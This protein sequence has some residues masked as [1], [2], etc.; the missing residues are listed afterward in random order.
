MVL[1]GQVKILDGGSDYG[2]SPC[3]LGEVPD[4]GDRERVEAVATAAH[5][6]YEQYVAAL[7]HFEKQ[8]IIDASRDPVENHPS[9]PTVKFTMQEILAR[10]DQ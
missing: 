8:E 10:L 2:G 5:V 9:L 4:L 1:V 3:R 6:T 7:D